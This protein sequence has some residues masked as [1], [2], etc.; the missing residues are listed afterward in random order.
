[1]CLLYGPFVLVKLASS[2]QPHRRHSLTTFKFEKTICW[3]SYSLPSL[4]ANTSMRHCRKM[5]LSKVIHGCL[6]AALAF[7][8]GVIACP[9]Y[10]DLPLYKALKKSNLSRD[11]LVKRWYTVEP[12]NE[13]QFNP[14]TWPDS[15]L[16]YCFEDDNARTQLE[17]IIE[18]AWNIW[19][20]ALV[21]HTL[22][23]I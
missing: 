15:T 12:S 10:D 8:T 21:T 23:F 18:S 22:P 19:Q 16:P 4:L 14:T 20:A 13:P 7:S 5:Q 6:C 1:M 17:H 3:S 2:T 9:D 11:E